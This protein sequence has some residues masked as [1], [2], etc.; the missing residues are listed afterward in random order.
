MEIDEHNRRHSKLVTSKLI[1]QLLCTMHTNKI[2]QGFQEVRQYCQFD[3]ICHN[4]LS[5]LAKVMENIGRFKLKIA[6][7]KWYSNGLNPMKCKRTA[8]LLSHKVYTDE[9]KLK[10]FCHWR[11]QYQKRISQYDN[12]TK[13]VRN[14]FDFKQKDSQIEIKR[15]FVIWKECLEKFKLQKMKVQKLIWRLYFSKLNT[16]MNTW[17]SHSANLDN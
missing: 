7:T 12:K 8:E 15:A 3:T 10:C 4:K 9:L 17:M 14:L 1:F 2:R 11:Q 16:A 6:F 5:Q 13:A